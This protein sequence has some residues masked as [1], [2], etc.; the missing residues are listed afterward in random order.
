MEFPSRNWAAF[1]M[2]ILAVSL[3]WISAGCASTSAAKAEPVKLT[4]GPSQEQAA[5]IQALNEEIAR[6]NQELDQVFSS[7]DD[8]ARAKS[9]LEGQLQGEMAAGDA[10]V[11]MQTR[12]LVVTVLDRILFD[13]GKAELKE[14]S[15]S[16]LKAVASILSDRVRNHM[17]YVEG[18]TD[19]IPIKFSGWKSNWELSSA[20]STEVVHRF[21]DHLGIDAR[22][23]AAVGYAEFHPIA[24]NDTSSGRQKNRRVE[25]VISPNK[26]DV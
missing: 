24:D 25:I 7:R 14:G 16:T 11:S 9:E 12:G 5:T 13:S 26:I 17:V 8:L 22:R 3:G 19:N 4:S 1:K 18:H 6:L 15:E 23:I 10:S 2:G 20:R 21:V